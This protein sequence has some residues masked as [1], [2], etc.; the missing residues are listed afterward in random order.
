MRA[1][2]RGE[3]AK[4][5]GAAFRLRRNLRNRRGQRGNLALRQGHIGRSVYL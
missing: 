1:G 3:G 2:N 5:G 4:S